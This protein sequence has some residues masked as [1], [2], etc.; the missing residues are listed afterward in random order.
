MSVPDLIALLIVSDRRWNFIGQRTLHQ[1]LLYHISLFFNRERGLFLLP[2]TLFLSSILRSRATAEDGRKGRGK[3]KPSL[4]SN[5]LAAKRSVL[6]T[7]FPNHESYFLLPGFRR[8][9]HLADSVKNHFKL[10][11][12]F[13]FH[14][15]Q[16]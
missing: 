16:L 2:L 8:C 11:I 10:C 5:S 14:F 4:F 15:F 7:A 12:V 6:Y 1:A 9:H 3:S 13:L